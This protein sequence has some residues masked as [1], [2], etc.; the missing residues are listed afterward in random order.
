[1]F[2]EEGAKIVEGLMEKAKK[3]NVEL[4]LPVD[5]VTGDKFAEDATVG[6]ATVSGGIPAGHMVSFLI[7][8]LLSW[9]YSLVVRELPIK[10]ISI[11]LV[12][13]NHDSQNKAISSHLKSD[14]NRMFRLSL[15]W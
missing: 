7:F 12:L 5:F 4:V 14:T 8:L 11:I 9:M 13:G 10:S 2:D 3:N 1:M 6:Q 15:S